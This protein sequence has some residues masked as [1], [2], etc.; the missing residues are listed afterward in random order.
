MRLY[1]YIHIYINIYTY[2]VRPRGY[3]DVCCSVAKGGSDLVDEPRVGKQ[4]AK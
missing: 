3:W 1:I 4:T 2:T